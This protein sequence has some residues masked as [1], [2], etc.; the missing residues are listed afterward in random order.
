M[1]SARYSR[2]G[3]SNSGVPVPAGDVGPASRV[4]LTPRDG[5]PGGADGAVAGEPAAVGDDVR[6]GVLLG[7]TPPL[8][9]DPG[10]G[11]LQQVLGQMPV[12]GQEPGGTQQPRPAGGHE[13]LELGPVAACHAA[14]A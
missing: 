7:D 8:R 1:I 11:A 3:P 9:P 14:L 5:V 13:L 2:S 6:L 4:G 10:Q 12:A